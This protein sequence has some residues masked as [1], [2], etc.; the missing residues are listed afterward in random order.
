MDI[1]M[2]NLSTESQNR[3]ILGELKR[4]PLG[5]TGMDMIR[6]FGA[7]SYTRRIKDLRDSGHKI[8][9]MWERKYDERG[10]EVKRWKRYYYVG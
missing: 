6:R 8:D 2:M 7:M 3:L 4:N 9:S 5:L 1:E 10:K